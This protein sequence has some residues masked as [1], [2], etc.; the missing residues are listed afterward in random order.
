M[1]ILLIVVIANLDLILCQT[2]SKGNCK[3]TVGDFA[4]EY[5]SFTKVSDV[6]FASWTAIETVSVTG[7][8]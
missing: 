2:C 6:K 3:K 7:K 1:F 5:S 8:K 4:V